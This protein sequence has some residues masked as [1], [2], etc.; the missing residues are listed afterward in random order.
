MTTSSSDNQAPIHLVLASL[1]LVP[2]ASYGFIRLFQDSSAVLPIIAAALVSG[3]LSVL[4]RLAKF[5]LVASLV[6]SLLGLFTL[7]ELRLA[8]GT[9]RIGVLPTWAT[10]DALRA[11]YD[12]GLG[13]FQTKKAPVTTLDSF[14]AASMAASWLMAF[15]TDWGA[16]RLRLSFEPVLPAGL[17]FFFASVLGSGQHALRTTVVFTSAVLIWSIVQRATNISSRNVWLASDA[18]RGPLGIAASGVAVAAAILLVGITLSPS[19]PG[20]E[21]DEL[22]YWRDKPD[23]TRSVVSPY[24]SILD[25]LVSQ[26]DTVMFTVVADE[27]A[28]WRVVGLDTYDPSKSIWKLDATFKSRTGDLP[29]LAVAT[30]DQY[31]NRQEFDIEALGSIWLPAAYS[32]TRILQ[33]T[34]PARWHAETSSLTISDE[35]ETNSGTQYV[36]ESVVS[37]FEPAELQSASPVVPSAIAE[38]YLEIP[39]GVSDVV[40]SEAQ[41]IT[42]GA[43]TRY[44]QML[45][46]QAYFHAFGY[47]TALEPRQG[48][49][50]EQFL[51]ERVGFCTHF[52]GTFALMARALGAPARVATGFTWG[53]PT[54]EPN[55]YSVTGRNAHA[56]PEVYFEGLGW[57]PFEPT[58]GRGAPN[59]EHTALP[60]AQAQDPDQT[61][62]LQP[63]T[64]LA[65]SATPQATTGPAPQQADAEQATSEEASDSVLSGVGWK[66]QALVAVLVGYLL[67]VPLA[68]R[69]LRGRRRSAALT[70]D[71]KI[72]LAW[73]QAMPSLAVAYGLRRIEAETRSEFADRA[74]DKGAE[75][76]P[77]LATLAE[78]ATTARFGP[79]A[80]LEHQAASAISASANIRKI[81]SDQVPWWRRWLQDLDLRDFRD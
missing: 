75:C 39:N 47:S 53:D 8:P 48:D 72:G 18:R 74:T 68:R 43:T 4:L 9:Q 40:L 45:A 65:P 22:Y 31:I 54:G 29:G 60:E 63:T 64:T 37:N 21:S 49:P 76:A 58:P 32:P 23:P 81:V 26:T 34:A 28:Y 71:E 59:T 27:P 57:V 24:V 19:I 2:A 44:E 51:N 36:I 10:L 69:W 6:V 70:A 30:S 16:L 62:D 79:A 1:L 52:S 17:L 61:T 33:S 80:A 11:I 15:L 46:L 67:G 73:R 77:D 66:L 20:S 14:V 13:D 35:L 56:W 3:G 78:I 41:A 38:R 55:E 50:I 12:T 7:L 25:Q 5:S 42:R